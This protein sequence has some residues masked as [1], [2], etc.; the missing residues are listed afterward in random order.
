MPFRR[1]GVADWPRSLD[2]AIV[3]DREITR[4]HRAAVHLMPDHTIHS[5]PGTRHQHH[6]RPGGPPTRLPRHLGL[7]VGAVIVADHL[8]R[9]DPARAGGLRRSCPGPT[10]AL[11]NLLSVQ[12]RLD[13]VAS[14]LS[15]LESRILVG[16]RDVAVVAQ[17]L[18]MV[19]RVRTRSR[20]TCSSWA[21]TAAGALLSLQLEELVTGIDRGRAGDPR[22]PPG[23]RGPAQESSLL[24]L[25]GLSAT[26]LVNCTSVARAL[27]RFDEERLN[28]ASPA[29]PATGCSPRS[30]ASH[31]LSSTGWSSASARCRSCSPPASTTCRSSTD[32]QLRAAFVRDLRPPVIHPRQPVW[33]DRDRRHTITR[34][35]VL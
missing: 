4:I 21:P 24:L 15:A 2:G 20:T 22:L 6:R 25:S 23:I 11:G 19:T 16:T 18:E 30:P 33:S 8:V 35:S 32:Q 34:L 9:R 31:P 1:N 29:R 27:L 28:T 17:R 12:M 3:L 5:G 13:E 7:P 10:T 26:E 14:T